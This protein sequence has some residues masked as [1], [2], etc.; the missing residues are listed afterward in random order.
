MNSI[1]AACF[2]ENLTVVKTLEILGFKKIGLER[3]RFFKNDSFHNILRYDLLKNEW[4][5]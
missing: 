4:K 2:E 5:F 1:L 3:A